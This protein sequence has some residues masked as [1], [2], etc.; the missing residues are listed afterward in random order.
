MTE[1]LATQP[2]AAETEL[3]DPMPALYALTQ[4]T[5][6]NLHRVRAVLGS[7]QPDVASLTAELVKTTT[8]LTELVTLAYANHRYEREILR[9]LEED[10]DDLAEAVEDGVGDGGG[11]PKQLAVRIATLLGVL[12]KSLE[13]SLHLANTEQK[14][15]SQQV[16]AECEACTRELGEYVDD[17]DDE[18]DS[19]EAAEA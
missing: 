4:K 5:H 3:P 19:D 8:L 1:A 11:I 10:T 12:A 15:Q 16:I 6:K 13:S 14:A 7:Q 18:D 17:E 9:D 2:S